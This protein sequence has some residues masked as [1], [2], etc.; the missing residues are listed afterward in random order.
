MSKVITLSAP[1]ARK[2][3]EITEVTITDAMKQTGSLRGLKMYDVMMSDVDSLIRLLPR[4]TNPALTELEVT[5]MDVADFGQLATAVAD[6]LTPASQ[7]KAE[8]ASE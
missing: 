8:Q 4:V 6:F 7:K 2:D 1:I 3:S 5:M